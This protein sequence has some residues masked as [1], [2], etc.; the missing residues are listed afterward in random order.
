MGLEDMPQPSGGAMARSMG[1]YALG[2]LLIAWVLAN[3][4]EVW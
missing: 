3:S 2:N 4:L 1:L